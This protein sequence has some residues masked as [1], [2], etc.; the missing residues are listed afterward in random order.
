MKKHRST[1]LA[2]VILSLVLVALLAASPVAR[3]AVGA[4]GLDWWTVAGGGGESSGGSYAVNGT[5]GQSGPGRLAGGA[6]ILEGGFWTG[7][8]PMAKVFIPLVVR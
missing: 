2:G 7:G 8:G 1:I 6:Y 3:A 5:L 4:L